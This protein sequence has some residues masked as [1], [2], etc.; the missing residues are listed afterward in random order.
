[1]KDFLLLANV[2]AVTYKWFFP[3]LKDEKVRAGYG[4][5]KVVMF[6][7]PEGEMKRQFAIAWYTTLPVQHKKLLLTKT[8]NPQDYPKYDNY[9]A[10]EVGMVKDMPFDYDGLMGVPITVFGY[11]LDNVEIIGDEIMNRKDAKIDDKEKYT[12]V[13]I[14]KNFEIT[15]MM[16]GAIG[17]GLTNGD[18]GRAKFYTNGKSVYTRILIRRKK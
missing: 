14:K 1:M 4:F 13:L 11:D 16:N 5:N 10:I 8:Y 12:R 2:N 6:E 7:T 18:D 17:E 3:L 9:D 15:S